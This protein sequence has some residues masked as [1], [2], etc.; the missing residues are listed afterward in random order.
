[1]NYFTEKNLP[2]LFEAVHSHLTEQE[3]AP[4]YEDEKGGVEKLIGVFERVKAD[5]FYP[6]LVSKGEL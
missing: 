5:T 2:F 6:S 1:M 3:H 4:H